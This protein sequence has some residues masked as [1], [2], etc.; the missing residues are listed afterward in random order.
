MLLCTTPLQTWFVY[1]TLPRVLSVVLGMA[2]VY[3]YMMG[4]AAEDD[5]E[6]ERQLR[7]KMESKAQKKEGGLFGPGK[8]LSSSG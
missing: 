3:W 5:K 6:V 1:G 7:E 8:D 4:V 2:S